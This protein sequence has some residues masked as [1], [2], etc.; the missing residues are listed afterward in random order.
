MTG[1]CL[2]WECTETCIRNPAAGVSLAGAV[3]V[4]VQRVSQRNAGKQRRSY[5]DDLGSDIEDEDLEEDADG[6][7]A[8]GSRPAHEDRRFGEPMIWSSVDEHTSFGTNGSRKT[9][10]TFTK[11]SYLSG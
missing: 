6:D 7:G 1:G 8:D 11:G 4:A 10:Y 5:A 9:Q 3:V 2:A